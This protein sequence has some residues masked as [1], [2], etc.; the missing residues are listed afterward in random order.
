[1]Y[2]LTVREDNSK[3]QIS[4][5]ISDKSGCLVMDDTCDTLPLQKLV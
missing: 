1:M 3:C 5:Q 4:C 2:L